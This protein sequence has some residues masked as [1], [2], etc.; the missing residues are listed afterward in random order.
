MAANVA[1]TR[2]LSGLPAAELAAS[3]REAE[4]RDLRRRLLVAR[5]IHAVAAPAER[6]RRRGRA[7]LSAAQWPISL[8]SIGPGRRR[9]KDTTPRSADPTPGLAG[10]GRPGR[11][12]H[13]SAH[14]PAP[15][16]MH[17]ALRTGQGPHDLYVGLQRPTDF[18]AETPAA[19]RSS[20]RPSADVEH[21]RDSLARRAPAALT[22]ASTN[23]Q[24]FMVVIS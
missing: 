17:T 11:R 5:I 3:A 21:E 15:S 24:G 7:A 10:R 19:A 14:S 6:V 18:P 23:A 1:C 22:R 12:I 13:G 20:A 4:E 16:D 8:A 9:A 2:P